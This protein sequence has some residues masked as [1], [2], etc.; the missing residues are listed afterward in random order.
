MTTE[1]S[2]A[3]GEKLFISYAGPDRAW[4]EWVAWQLEHAGYAVEL[5]LWDWAAGDNLVMRI[6]QALERADR[7][8]ALFSEAYFEHQRFTTDEWTAVMSGRDRQGKLIPLRLGDVTLPTV[9]RPLVAPSLAER[10]AEDAHRV[11]LNAVRG[12]QRP[13][14]EPGFPGAQVPRQRPAAEAPR[15]PGG[16]QPTLWQVPSRN[17]DFVGRD[18]DLDAVRRELRPGRPVVV[19]SGVP[20]GGVGKTQ[21]A[22]EYVHRFA[23]Q[24]DLVVWINAEEPQLVPA[25]L[26]AL[27]AELGLVVEHDEAGALPALRRHL[28]QPKRWLLVFD[29]AETA[30]AVQPWVHAGVGHVLITSRSRDWSEFA[31]VNLELLTRRE[32][33]TLLRNRVPELSAED[34][35][36]VADKLGDLP[37]A[38]V[39]A[40][41]VLSTM[42]AELY[43]QVLDTD[44][45]EVL[46]EGLPRSYPRSL[47]AALRVSIN[48]LADR[49]EA[50]ALL[51]LCCVLASE[52]IPMALLSAAP[53]AVEEPL[54]S[55]VVSPMRLYRTTTQLGD[56]VRL[57]QRGIQVH[58]LVQTLVLSQL[59][60]AT[61]AEL[62]RQA[63]G[64]LAA[65]HP[66]D[67]ASASTWPAWSTLMPHLLA[68]DL[69]ETE[70]AEVRDAACDAM[71]YLLYSGNTDSGFGL[72]RNLYDKWRQN[73]GPDDRHTLTAATELAHAL[74][75]QGRDREALDLTE[76][77]LARRRRTLGPNDPATLRSASDYTVVIAALGRLNESIDRAEDLLARR[78]EV[79]GADHRDTLNTRGQIATVW[80]ETGNLSAAVSG[81]DQLLIDRLRVLGADHRDTLTTRSNLATWKGRAGDHHT[82]ITAFAELLTD[83]LRV[84]GPDHPATLITRSN[85]ATWK[86]ETGDHTAITAFEELLTD[87]LR[88]LGP[89]HPDTL[90]TRSNLATWKGRAGDHHTAITAFAELLTDQL[91]VL[92]PDH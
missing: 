11:L 40:A 89:D 55:V 64:L 90:S 13:T 10:S 91:R 76:D 9:L 69:G 8:V 52:P 71:L 28:Q 41:T 6:N 2:A 92:G 29:N 54:R 88:V 49:G 44:A 87:R 12:P 84:L 33:V 79:L 59:D 19:Q 73:L 36:L 58:R 5:D 72:A 68:L 62:R 14:S 77:T 42:P 35:N 39:Q 83:Q 81:L 17:A 75:N 3:T 34:A 86:G 43:L 22:V 20:L 48:G 63:G 24:Y 82:A 1:A 66:G 47:A 27:A 16:H 46:N 85:L 31:R 26:T 45:D 30:E 65:S 80:G 78:I 57:S 4:A 56:L 25:Q 70:E 67:P 61:R 53:G 7:M 18:R 21:V 74:H 32:S 50:L 51:H 23:A 15:L 60:A 38:L 37:L